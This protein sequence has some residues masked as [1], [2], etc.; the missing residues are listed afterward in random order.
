VSYPGY[1]TSIT[2]SGTGT[3]PF[4]AD[5]CDGGAIYGD[6]FYFWTGTQAPQA[7]DPGEGCL[8]EG[9]QP[10]GIPPYNANHQYVL[11]AFVVTSGPVAF[12]FDSPYD[13]TDAENWSI[14][15]AICFLGVP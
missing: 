13:E 15:G 2:L 5:N 9:S 7:Y 8:I 3:N 12:R 11:P 14:T 1:V 10:S 4:G 6:A